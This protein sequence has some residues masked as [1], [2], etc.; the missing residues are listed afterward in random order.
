MMLRLVLLL[1]L[2]GGGEIS[3]GGCCADTIRPFLRDTIGIAAGVEKDID[4]SYRIRTTGKDFLD[5]FRKDAAFDYKVSPIQELGWW[6]KFIAWLNKH[7]FKLE[8]RPG[9]G[10][11]WGIFIRITACL[12]FVFLL[13]KLIRSNKYLFFSKKEERFLSEDFSREYLPD[14]GS[15]PVRLEK[16]KN[17]GDYVLAVRILYLSTLRL[18]DEKKWICWDV[19]KTNQSYLFEIQDAGKRMGFQE[20]SRI[21]DCVCYGEFEIGEPVFLQVEQRFKAFQ[22][23]IEYAG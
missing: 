18:L 11:L 5:A 14:T 3:A 20:L 8:N 10:E 22:K 1:M 4:S 13:Y 19:H 21:F 9:A 16:A 6:R 23:E 7:D 15:Y 2:W 12:I 17:E